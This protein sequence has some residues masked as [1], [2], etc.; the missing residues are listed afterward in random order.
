MS[1]VTNNT[2]RDEYF[3]RVLPLVGT[4][5]TEQ[6]I[7][8]FGGAFLARTIELLASC[9]VMRFCLDNRL[10]MSNFL[11]RA[12]GSRD[13]SGDFPIVMEAYLRHQNGFENRWDFDPHESP[14][15]VLAGG[16]FETLQD[17]HAFG[18]ERN[19][20]IIYGALLHGGRSI[21]SVCFPG[22]PF[23]FPSMTSDSVVSEISESNYMDWVDLNNQSAHL[24]KAVML[25]GTKWESPDIT[26]LLN[27]NK[28]MVI[29]GHP[30]WPWPGHFVTTENGSEIS[31]RIPTAQVSKRDAS[32]G[33]HRNANVLIIGIGSL[34]S[35]I[36]DHFRIMGANVIGIDGKDVSLFNPVRQLYPTSSIGKPKAHELPGILA[37]RNGVSFK[38][39]SCGKSDYSVVCANGQRFTGVA[40]EIEDSKIGST[41]F[42]DILETY[43]PDLVILTTAH[44]AEFRMA[45]ILRKRDLPHVLG[46]C[47]PRARWFE[48]IVVDG[49]R[50][51]CY[52]CLQGHLYTGEV[53]SL[54]EEELARYDATPQDPSRE[55]LA[56]E[57]ATRIDTARAADAVARIGLELLLPRV[58]RAAW[59]ER[60]ISEEKTCLIGGNHAEY[61]HA[62]EVWSLGITSPGSAMLYGVESFIG[63]ADEREEECLYCGRM[64]R[65]TI[66][67][68]ET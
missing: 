12:L 46:R 4:S 9:G 8:V 30:S 61:R 36:A 65:I 39:T 45:Q 10:P 20:P 37:H 38:E 13:R 66:P 67:I 7:A 31:G 11:R 16:S 24:A 59:L 54:T 63:S 53:P 25:V 42:T 49:S 58:R 27:Q 68:T 50:G 2:Q 26:A 5:L 17:A 14:H 51:P 3:S 62:E 23:P 57:P 43:A 52:G 35:L 40:A 34:G 18:Q 44:P 64:N 15:I 56:A 48:A 28:R 6:A 33:R 32:D 47:Y 22:D 1:T 60:M 29:T 19:I 21:V 55:M 41:A